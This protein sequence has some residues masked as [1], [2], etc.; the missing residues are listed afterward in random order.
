MIDTNELFSFGQIEISSALSLAERERAEKFA[1]KARFERHA[2]TILS[3]ESAMD[4]YGALS[5]YAAACAEL[6]GSLVGEVMAQ[7]MSAYIA[8]RLIK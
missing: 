5:V 7:Q 3:F 1:A 2:E 4:R 8:T 6:F